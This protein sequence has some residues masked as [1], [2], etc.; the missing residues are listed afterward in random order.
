MLV[1]ST[2]VTTYGLDASLAH[3]ALVQAT[4]DLRSSPHRLLSYRVLHEWKLEAVAQMS[5]A[6]IS[7]LAESII[8]GIPGK[9]LMPRV[10]MD[11]DFDSVFF[12]GKAGPVMRVSFL[13]GAVYHGYI[14]R[15]VIPVVLKPI[16]VRRALGLKH[17]AKKEDVWVAV[18]HIIP[19]T[20]PPGL[21]KDAWFDLQDALV[22]A[23]LVATAPAD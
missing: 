3:G 17:T 23:Y 15:K 16:E 10:G 4:W 1:N 2:S 20:R 7:Q 19:N 8:W 6:R 5:P 14:S 21:T 22:L 12:K 18:D 13:M 11:F 9:A